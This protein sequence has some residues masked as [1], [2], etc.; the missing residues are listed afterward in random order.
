LTDPPSSPPRYDWEARLASL[1]ES[2]FLSVNSRLVSGLKEGADRPAAGGKE[3]AGAVLEL[4][5]VCGDR[6]SGEFMVSAAVRT[7][8]QHFGLAPLNL[9]VKT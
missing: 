5:V 6:A 1:Q 3:A 2:N 7:H 4:C 8:R 9:S